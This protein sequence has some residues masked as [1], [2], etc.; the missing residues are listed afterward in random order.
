MQEIGTM[1][2]A[3]FRSAPS[4]FRMHGPAFRASPTHGY[5]NRISPDKGLSQARVLNEVQSVLCPCPNSPSTCAPY[6]QFGFALS[7]T[8]TRSHR[9]NEVSVRSLAGLGVNVADDDSLSAYRHIRR[10]PLHDS[11]PRSQLPSP[12]TKFD[13]RF[14]IWYHALGF[15]LLELSTG[16]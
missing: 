11:L 10:L 4:C 7:C 8:L 13:V 6:F 12:R 3:D 2:A 15:K 1:A 14:Y 5:A 9:P 16:D